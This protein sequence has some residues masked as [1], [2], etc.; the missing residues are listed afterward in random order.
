MNWYKL[1]KTSALPYGYWITPDNEVLTVVQYEGHYEVL[2]KYKLDYDEA[3][4]AGWVRICIRADAMFVSGLKQHIERTKKILKEI[5]EDSAAG[6]RHKYPNLQNS[7]YNILIY[8]RTEDGIMQEYY[9]VVIN[10]NNIIKQL[11]EIESNET[12]Q[13]ITASKKMAAKPYGY[14]IKPDGELVNVPFEE[15]SIISRDVFKLRDMYGAMRAGYIHVINEADYPRF[16]TI[17]GTTITSSQINT[18]KGMIEKRNELGVAAIYV[19]SN[20]AANIV[21][22]QAKNSI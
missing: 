3:Y 21:N 14:W 16:T 4:K 6:I 5:H 15:H 13:K 10:E 8:I 22:F 17:I 12:L 2:N 19:I 18:I 20:G 9:P 11:N 7:T 1:T